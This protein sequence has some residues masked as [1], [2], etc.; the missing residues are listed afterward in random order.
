MRVMVLGAYGVI[1]SAVLTR[2]HRDGHAVVALG[3][4]VRTAHRRFPFAVWVE[5]DFHRMRSADDWLPLLAGFDAVVNCVGAFQTGSR[6]RL[7]HIHVD[8]PTALFAACEL[9]GVHRVVHVSAIGAEAASPTEFGRTK[10]AAEAALRASRL[11]W[12]ILRPGVVLAPGAYGGSALLL[13]LAGVPLCTPLMPAQRT[14]QI[15]SVEDVAETVAWALRPDAPAQLTFDLAHPQMLHL[16]EIVLGLRRWLGFPPQPVWVLPRVLALAVAKVTDA[17]GWLGWRSPARSTGVAQLAAGV[18]GDPIRW[19]QHTGIQP[20][21]F[22]DI[23][24][25]RPAT[26]QD[27][28]FARLYTLKPLAIAGLAVFWIATGIL[29]LGPGYSASLAHLSAAGFGAGLATA[30]VIGG[31]LFDIVLGLMLLVRRLAKPILITMLGA[32][33]GYVLAGTIIAPQLWIDPLGPLTKILPML[34]ATLFTLAVID[35]R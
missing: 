6:D 34:L 29:A 8:A 27:R 13:G 3:R 4:V 20:Q 18:V 9:A 5:A 33:A 15:V 1:G 16:H 11:D 24:A 26:L 22:D 25:R 32:T 19:T 17:L 7:D 10:A 21:S 2:L 12:L 30:A 23:L 35:E 31:A 28:W 14:I